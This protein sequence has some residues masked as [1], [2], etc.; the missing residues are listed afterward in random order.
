M[1]LREKETER[2]WEMEEER[3]MPRNRWGVGRM[4]NRCVF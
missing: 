3:R 2:S 4:G 1:D